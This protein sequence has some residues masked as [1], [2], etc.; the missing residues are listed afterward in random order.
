MEN[1]ASLDARWTL[2]GTRTEDIDALPSAES[3]ETNERLILGT[4]RLVN[5]GNITSESAEVDDVLFC[6]NML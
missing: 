4:V 1:S 3:S 6:C 2:R 5:V